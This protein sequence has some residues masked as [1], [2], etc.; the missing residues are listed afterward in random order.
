[1]VEDRQIKTITN[2]TRHQTSFPAS[3][4]HSCKEKAA[5]VVG[6]LIDVVLV[7][8][9]IFKLMPRDAE[10]KSLIRDGPMLRRLS[11]TNSPLPSSRQRQKR[12]TLGMRIFKPRDMMPRRHRLPLLISLAQATLA[13]PWDFCTA[14]TLN[15]STRVKLTRVPMRLGNHCPHQRRR[16]Y[17]R[18]SETVQGCRKRR[19]RR[20]CE[21]WRFSCSLRG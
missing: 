18:G 4:G 21:R 17:V 14:L 1:M 10:K 9:I 2:L 7:A 8:A 16:I 11:E 15:A 13:K 3:A 6:C 20:G 5:A 12:G 19:A